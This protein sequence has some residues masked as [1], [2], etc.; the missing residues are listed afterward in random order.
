MRFDVL[1]LILGWTLIAIS[2][3]LLICGVITVWLDDLEMALRGFLI[4]LILELGSKME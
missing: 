4:P 2:I 3:P 1:S